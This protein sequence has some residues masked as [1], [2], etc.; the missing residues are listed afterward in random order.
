MR[1]KI[2]LLFYRLVRITTSQVQ[3]GHGKPHHFFVCLFLYISMEWLLFIVQYFTNSLR[4]D[5]PEG[6]NRRVSCWTENMFH[7][8]RFLVWKKMRQK[9]CRC[10]SIAFQVRVMFL[11][12]LFNL[13]K[14]TTSQVEKRQITMDHIILFDCLVPPIFMNYLFGIVQYFTISFREIVPES[15]IPS[16]L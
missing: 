6:R 5:M 16:T 7:N 8:I 2:T 11:H 3:K 4:K 1:V 13:T 10:M 12:L 15:P 14:C 9:N